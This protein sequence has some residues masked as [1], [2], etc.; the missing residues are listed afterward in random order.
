VGA[1]AGV[2]AMR[3]SRPLGRLGIGER[4]KRS[5]ISAHVDHVVPSASS[6]IANVPAIDINPSPTT[7]SPTISVPLFQYCSPPRYSIRSTFLTLDFLR[8]SRRYSDDSIETHLNNLLP[9][10]RIFSNP[11]PTVLQPQNCAEFIRTQLLPTWSGRDDLLTYCSTL[12]EKPVEESSVPQTVEVSE[13]ID[14]YARRKKE[15]WEKHDE[16]KRIITQERGVEAVIRLRTWDLVLRRCQLEGL[17]GGW[18]QEMAR[19]KES[20]Q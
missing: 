11:S 15:V 7:V 13:R 20:K 6:R 19:W 14:P 2:Q 4:P 18:E 1:A 5:E 3:S 16:L 9:P 10:R 12:A 8:K 17:V